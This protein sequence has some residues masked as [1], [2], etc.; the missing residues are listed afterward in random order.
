MSVFIVLLLHVILSHI[1]G[2]I[3]G[4]GVLLAWFFGSFIG[5]LLFG[6][7]E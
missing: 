4:T 5:I 6:K 1:V 7:D 2:I 3:L